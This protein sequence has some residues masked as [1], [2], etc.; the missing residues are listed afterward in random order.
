MNYYKRA[1]E[2]LSDDHLKT[3]DLLYKIAAN[4]PG[5]IVRAVDREDK[6]REFAALEQAVRDKVAA[7]G[8]RVDAVRLWRA[9]T[10][11]TLREALGA[12]NKIMEDASSGGRDA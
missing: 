2:I 3:R 5:A 11:C 1:I 7:G 8:S 12:Y 6:S 10:G 4:N 9:K